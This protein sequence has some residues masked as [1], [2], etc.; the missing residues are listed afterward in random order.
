MDI[1]PNYGLC[2]EPQDAVQLTDG[3]HASS[4]TEK[5]MVGWVNKPKPA[6]T[7]DLGQVYAID[8]IAFRAAT[9]SYA[10]VGFPKAVLAFVSKDNKQFYYCRNILVDSPQEDD[11]GAMHRFVSPS[12]DTEAQYVKLIFVSGSA[13]VFIDEIEV[14]SKDRPTGQTIYDP[15]Q[16][17]SNLDIDGLMLHGKK[18]MHQRT[19]LLWDLETAV[20]RFESVD[21][22]LAD[23]LKGSADALKNEILSLSKPVEMD[24]PAGPPYTELHRKIYALHGQAASAMLGSSGFVAWKADPWVRIRPLSLPKS[25]E[26]NMAW[27]LKLLGNEYEPIAFNLTNLSD[28]DLAIDVSITGLAVTSKIHEAVFVETLGQQIINDA[29]PE[30]ASVSDGVNR[31]TIAS[32]MT[33]QVWIILNTAE[34]KAGNHKGTV[35]LEA[36]EKSLEFPVKLKVLP[37]R[38]ADKKHINTYSWAYLDWPILI[39]YEKEAVADLQAHYQNTVVVK[40][41]SIPKVKLDEKGNVLP[42]DFTAMDRELDLQPGMDMYLLWL[43][44][45]FPDPLG[46][47]GNVVDVRSR[48]NWAIQFKSWHNQMVEHLKSK[49]IDYDRFALYLVDE[50]GEDPTRGDMPFLDAVLYIKSINPNVLTYVDDCV[51]Q[52]QSI[53]IV[54]AAYDILCPAM[55]RVE[56]SNFAE[57]YRKTGKRIWSYECSGPA[58]K[59][60]SPLAYYRRQMWSAWNAGFTGAGFWAYADTGWGNAETPNRSAWDDFDKSGGDFGVVY[61][62]DK[63]PVSSRRWEAWREGVEDFEYLWILRDKV[64]EAQKKAD[65]TSA[66][67]QGRR[68]LAEAPKIFME[69]S[70]TAPSD[71]AGDEKISAALS[72]ARADIINALESLQ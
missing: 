54:A 30:A 55:N 31:V 6:V 50:P 33:K 67:A 26:S 21:S 47:K 53:P 5:G 48:K 29:L 69:A 7:I 13:F 56:A 9:G 20:S 15:T 60:M 46:I 22:K 16:L 51:E 14:L 45:D 57:I 49:G 8:R 52:P 23:E 59:R 42:L 38:I 71:P 58:N 72:K 62:S 64:N 19:R 17:E 43:G 27:D 39:G 1:P 65:S 61:E 66:V 10:A 2:T 37:V 36:G 70:K 12:L 25:A 41:G 3:E 28:S 4:W 44:F 34:T 40:P 18:L 11:S 24:L 32:G 68:A 63:G 35:C